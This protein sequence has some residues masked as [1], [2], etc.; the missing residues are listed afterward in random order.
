MDAVLLALASAFLFGSMTVALR[1]ALRRGT[2][3]EAGALLTILV[4]VV[5][6]LP[7]VAAT[8]TCQPGCAPMQRS[9]SSCAYAETRSSL[10]GAV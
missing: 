6:T 4:A 3:A 10:T 5:V 8:S 7:F 1:Y 9:T 2:D